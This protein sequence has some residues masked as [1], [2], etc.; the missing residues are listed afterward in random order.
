[1]CGG[2]VEF[3]PGLTAPAPPWRPFAVPARWRLLEDSVAITTAA[4]MTARTST[5]EIAAHGRT[6]VRRRGWPVP[7]SARVD[8]G[9]RSACVGSARPAAKVLVTPVAAS[10]VAT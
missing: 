7:A 2:G 10:P 5:A 6:P 1:M 9:P 4:A 3:A 8:A